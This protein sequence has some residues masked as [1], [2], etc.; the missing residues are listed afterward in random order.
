MRTVLK[1]AIVVIIA[2]SI[3]AISVFGF[4]KYGKSSLVIKNGNWET[5]LY[6][7]SPD[8]DIYTRALTA[9]YLL[10]ALNKSEA[11]YFRTYVDNDGNKLK[12]ECDYVIKGKDPECRWWSIT[13]YGSDLFL[14][15]NEYNKYSKSIKNTK[16][17]SDGTFTIKVSPEF[18]DG[19]WIPV[20]KKG[21][22][23]LVIRLYNPT[24]SVYNNITTIELPR[25]YKEKCDEN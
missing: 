1:W 18:K 6:N 17:N 11:I 13:A 25:I 16:R 2:V 23:V 8:A 3:A 5:S 9:V 21:D 24:E 19:N 20:G 7:G 14:I 4:L 22:F 10:F 15:P 12:S